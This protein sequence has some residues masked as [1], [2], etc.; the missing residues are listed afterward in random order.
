MLPSGSG[1]IS[2]IHYLL[3]FGGG[4]LLCFFTGI[5]VLE[6]YFFAPH[7]SSGGSCVPPTPSAVCV[8]LNLL[9]VF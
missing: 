3:C 8:L 1:D 7:P 6:V 5:S 2:V 4:L 9:F